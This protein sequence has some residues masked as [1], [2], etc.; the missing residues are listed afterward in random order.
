MKIAISGS[1]GFIGSRLCSEFK[2][3]EWEVVELTRS[4]FAKDD[5][6][7]SKKISGCDVI[8]NLA[9]APIMKRWTERYK[10][11]I[12]LSRIAATA[13]IVN[14]ICNNIKKPKL[15]I[16][17][18]AT[19]IYGSEGIWD[20]ENYSYSGDFLGEVCQAWEKEALK[21]SGE[22]RTVIVR[23][24]VVLD[25]KQG[26]LAKML[27]LFRFGIGGRIGSGKQGFSW[28]HIN[29][30]IAS[31]I[32]IINNNDI[33]GS[34]N[35]VAPE[36][37]D[38][39]SFTK[40]LAKSLKRPAFFVVPEFTLKVLYGKGAEVLT[41]GQKVI[42]KKLTASGYNYLFPTLS[43]ALDAILKKSI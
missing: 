23:F 8:I 28:I 10:K 12:L 17:A 29:D 39:R 41:K 42:P 13:K 34:V 3:K 11:T 22:C 18:S 38:N 15:F 24:G 1:T 35:I 19:G 27:P 33:N 2:K 4:D 6:A 40:A 21:A 7:F 32:F 26:A 31:I 9:G 37:T 25:K 43:S 36:I 20:E 16:S 14:S 5:I 30:L